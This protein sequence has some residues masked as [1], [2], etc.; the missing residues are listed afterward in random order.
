MISAACD[1]AVVLGL[2]AEIK[3]TVIYIITICIDDDNSNNNRLENAS[4]VPYRAQLYRDI[5]L[6]L[7][8][9]STTHDIL[10][11][12]YG[13]ITGIGGVN[14]TAVEDER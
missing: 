10:L 7:Y 4:L 11:L 5:I 8:V 3:T 13:H 2:C 6:Y 1:S 9:Y 14:H 12:L